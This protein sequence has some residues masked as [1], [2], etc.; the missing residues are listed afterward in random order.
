MLS[1][2]RPMCWI[3]VDFW[4]SPEGGRVTPGNWAAA[5]PAASAATASTARARVAYRIMGAPSEKRIRVLEPS[6]AGAAERFEIS[7]AP[8]PSARGR[9]LGRGRTGSITPQVF[10][11]GVPAAA[12]PVEL[13][14]DRVLLVVILVVLLGGIERGSGDDLGHHLA[15]PKALLHLGLGGFGLALLLGIVKEDRRAVLLAVIAELSVRG[16]RVHV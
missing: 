12:R 5:G 1:L 2:T 6:Y 9:G 8:S 7:G 10:Q 15:V 11:P 3:T 14:A 4:L 13:V 16:E